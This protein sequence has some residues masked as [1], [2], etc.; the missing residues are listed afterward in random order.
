MSAC[1]VS[2]G[3]HLDNY[4]LGGNLGGRAD[5][6]YA[7]PAQLSADAYDRPSVPIPALAPNESKVLTLAFTD[8]ADF[9]IPGFSTVHHPKI[10]MEHWRWLYYGAGGV[11]DARTSAEVVAGKGSPLEKKDWVACSAPVKRPEPMPAT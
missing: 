10:P 8:F 2:V 5:Y 6:M 11:L 7:A 4:F 9:V 3:L 1:K